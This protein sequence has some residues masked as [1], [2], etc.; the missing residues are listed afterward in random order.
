[1]PE[2][3]MLAR[4]DGTFN[5]LFMQTADVGPTMFYGHGAGM[6]P[7]GSA[8]AADIMSAARDICC[9]CP[10]RLL[11]LPAN[12]ADT[13]RL[14]PVREIRSRYY[15]RFTADDSPGVLSRIS[16]VLGRNRI[17]ISSVI[18]KGRTA[19]GGTVPI[20]MLTH[21]ACESDM[22]KAMR[23]IERLALVRQ[24]TMLIRIADDLCRE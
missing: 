12:R 14:Q 23:Q 1:V 13:T 17:S 24:K 11:L 15:L 7:T 3:H 4:V 18:Q 9:G 20:F 22:Q 2:Q 16:G 5:A 10:D 6:L 19:H 8:V 21:D